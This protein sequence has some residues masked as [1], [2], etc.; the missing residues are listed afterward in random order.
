MTE[1][2]EKLAYDEALRGI[3]LQRQ[4]LESLQSRA[5]TLLGAAAIVT[6]FFGGQALQGK[7]AVGTW[8]WVAVGAF[9]ALAATT[10]V[11]LFP[12]TFHFLLDP[13]ELVKNYVDEKP[14]P[15]ANTMLRDLALHHVDSHGK[16]LRTMK[17]LHRSFRAGAVLLGVEV[18]AWLLAR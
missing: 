6:S 17:W 15:S 16:N 13:E 7:G 2:L 12:L 18:L 14:Q 3:E 8:G 4:G 9:I 5:G 1:V 10:T 11:V